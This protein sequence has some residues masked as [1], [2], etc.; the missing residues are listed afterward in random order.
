MRILGSSNASLGSYGFYTNLS[1][2]SSA[3]IG[4]YDLQVD[5]D[6]GIYYNS[7]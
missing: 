5:Y 1:I 4:T 6:C 3:D 7:L 2:P